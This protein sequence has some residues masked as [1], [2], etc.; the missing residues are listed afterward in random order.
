MPNNE[1]TIRELY[2]AAEGS[3][4]D[5]AKFVSMFSDEG[6]M[7]DMA[8]STKFRG[9]AIVTLSTPSQRHSLSV[10][11]ELFSICHGERR[12]RRARHSGNA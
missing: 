6:Y 3:G 2:A 8:S 12:R 5:T 10:H 1:E 11:R 4:K 9:Q 7:C